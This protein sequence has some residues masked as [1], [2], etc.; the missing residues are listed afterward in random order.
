M[1]QTK[2]SFCEQL[3]REALQI[4]LE[5]NNN[6]YQFIKRL[7]GRDIIYVGYMF[8]KAFGISEPYIQIRAL[9]FDW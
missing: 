7:I 3:E 6:Q 4:K 1:K 8:G 2:V 9:G 5:V